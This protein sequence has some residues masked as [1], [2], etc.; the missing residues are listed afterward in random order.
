MVNTSPMESGALRSVPE[1]T[2]AGSR[3]KVTFN[4]ALNRGPRRVQALIN[5]LQACTPSRTNATIEHDGRA[6]LNAIVAEGVWDGTCVFFFRMH[7]SPSIRGA[8]GDAINEELILRIV[9]K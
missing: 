8:F 4:A 3:L 2:K 1:R 6:K 7:A 9:K 5:L